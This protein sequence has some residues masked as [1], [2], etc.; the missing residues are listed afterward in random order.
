MNIKL[1]KTLMLASLSFVLL[2]IGCDAT[3]SDG[4]QPS[5]SLSFAVKSSAQPKAV[6]GNSLQSSHVT[7]T[8]AKMLIREVEFESD[9]EDD[10]IADDSLE[11]ETGPFVV[12]LNLNGALNTIAV[13]NVPAGSYDEIEFEVHKPEDNE[14]PPDPDFKIGTSGDERFSVIIRG[15]YNGQEFLYRSNENMEQEIELA[16]PLLIDEQTES[17]NVTMSVD[18]SQWFVSETGS[19]LDPTDENVRDQID[20][21]IKRSFEAFQDDDEDGEDDSNDD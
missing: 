18:L 15:T 7:I 8:E 3:N 12:E 11:F 9:L 16:S 6:T 1:P 19:D 2:M 10:G 20:E 5:L 17:I 13:K 21:S 14:T 4:N